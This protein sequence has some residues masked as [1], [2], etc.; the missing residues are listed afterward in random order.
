MSKLNVHT[1]IYTRIVLTQ[2]II[3]ICKVCTPFTS[4]SAWSQRLRTASCYSNTE[5]HRIIFCRRSKKKRTAWSY[6]IKLEQLLYKLWD[7]GQFHGLGK[8]I[9]P[10]SILAMPTSYGHYHRRYWRSCNPNVSGEAGLVW[11]MNAQRGLSVE[12]SFLLLL[13]VD[14]TTKCHLTPS[15]SMA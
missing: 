6:A 14:G 15:R 3:E 5:E 7:A 10:G 4:I 8:D 1:Y 13:P 11:T 12:I 2:I 9:S